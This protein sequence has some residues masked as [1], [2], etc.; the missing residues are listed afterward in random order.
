[1]TAIGEPSAEFLNYDHRPARPGSHRDGARMMPTFASRLWLASGSGAYAALPVL[2]RGR[3][4]LDSDSGIFLGVA[5][6]LLDGDRLYIDN[7]LPIRSTSTF[8]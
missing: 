2:T 6:R 4:S 8:S 5:G 3:P 1:M 7:A